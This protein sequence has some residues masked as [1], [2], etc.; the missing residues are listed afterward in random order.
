MQLPPEI[1]LCKSSVPKFS[2]DEFSSKSNNQEVSDVKPDTSEV[3]MKM[4]VYED[5]SFFFAPPELRNIGIIN[6]SSSPSENILESVNRDYTME[7]CFVLDNSLTNQDHKGLIL[8]VGFAAE[9]VNLQADY[10]QLVNYRDCE[11]RAA[12]FQRLA[13]DLNSQH[14]HSIE[15]HDA[16]IDAL[17]LA[18][19]CYVNPFFLTSKARSNVLSQMKPSNAKIFRKEIAGQKKIPG[20]NNYNMETITDLE[21][22]RDKIVLQLLLEAA[23]LDLEYQ[24]K[25][26]EG[27]LQNTFEEPEGQLINLSLHDMHAADAVTLVRQNQVLLCKFLIQRLQRNQH[28][29]QEILMHCLVFF[30]QSATKLYCNPEVVINI[31]LGSADFLHKILSSLHGQLKEGNC[32]LPPEKILEVQRYWMLLQRLVISSTSGDEVLDISVSINRGLRNGNLIPPSVWVQKVSTFSHCASVLVRFL[33]WMAISRNA[34]QFIRDRVFLVSDL[35]QITHLLSIFGDELALV[36]NVVDRKRQDLRIEKSGTKQTP[37]DRSYEFFDQQLG[38]QSFSVVYPDLSRFFPNL[39]KQFDTFGETILEAVGLQ[40]RSLPP[41]AVPDILCW[42]SDLCLWPF[43]QKD[44]TIGQNKSYHSKGFVARNAK[45]VILYV[46]EAIVIEHMEAMVPEIPRIVQVLVSLCKTSYCDVSFLDSILHVLKPIITYSLN[47]IS[48]E[49]KLLADDSCVNFESLCFDELFDNMKKGIDSQDH[50]GAKVH[51]IALTIFILGS[52]F[53]DLSFGRRREILQSLAAWADFPVCE[54]TTMFHDYLCAFHR[55]IGS[56]RYFLVQTLR[57]LGFVPLHD[58]QS[59]DESTGT[60]FGYSTESKSKSWFF[61]CVSDASSFTQLS[62]KV[63]GDNVDDVISDKK[64]LC[65]SGN[66]IEDFT[67]DLEGL[68]AKLYPTIDRCWNF[69]HQLARKITMIS[70][71]CFMFSRCL[72]SVAPIIP[73]DEED[74]SSSAFPLKL[75]DQ[76]EVHWKHGLKGLAETVVMLQ[77]NH[78]WEVASMMLDCLLELPQCFKLDNVIDTICFAIKIFSCTAPKMV[79]RLQT[80]KWLSLLFSRSSQSLNS[81]EIPL[82]DMFS[83]M[84]SHPEPEQ[85]LVS[86]Q[87]LSK[88]VAQDLSGGTMTSYSTSWTKLVS[89]SLVSSVSEPILSSMVSSTWDQV[90]ALAS[91]ELSLPLRTRAMALLVD[92]IPFA[93]RQNLQSLLMAAD[94]VLYGFGELAHP[95]CEGPLLQLSLAL[96]AGACLYSPA[97]DL[98]LI[99]QSVWKVIETL[100]SKTGEALVEYCEIHFKYM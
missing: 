36:D 40:L 8:D 62:N 78:C 73:T 23:N 82:L 11:L 58:S 30:L 25:M 84:L 80:D 68:I 77:E 74:G 59:L 41:S 19:E 28:S 93:E 91:S 26:S 71:Q 32:K 22:K 2:E 24:K 94:S 81:C 95:F 60:Y 56:C 83:A 29:M 57:V 27:E 86:L 53:P 37:M 66:E 31:I 99:P 33:G 1:D 6:F 44:Q 45:A 76:F 63:E 48:E 9:Y 10:L 35:S 42:F 17:L 3:A 15:C 75:N 90:V 85:R 46:L 49:E 18:A 51:S 43:V 79:W 96:I 70:A 14:E 12:E 54:P 52:I 88:L 7:Q 20:K 61:D 4:D 16:A 92:Y 87:H 13:S 39:K 97:E 72:C 47:K 64:T 69:H 89:P 38:D 98:S 21:K 50:S 55:V 65:L 67:R 34:K 100:G 5:A